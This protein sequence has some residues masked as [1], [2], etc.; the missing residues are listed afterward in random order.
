MKNGV[1]T[2]E[3]WTS[4]LGASGLTT[5]AAQDGDAMVRAAACL[6]VALVVA[7]YVLSRAS[8]KGGGA[9]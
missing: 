2:S 7:V 5:V 3:W 1:Q 9:E 8:V 6:G 4:V